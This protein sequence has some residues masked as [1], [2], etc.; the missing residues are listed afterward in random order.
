MPK[1]LLTDF[2]IKL[3]KDWFKHSLVKPLINSILT[4][5]KVIKARSTKVVMKTT[6]CM[7]IGQVTCNSYLS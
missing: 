5:R 2:I 3:Y 1:F 6:C 4:K 7:Q